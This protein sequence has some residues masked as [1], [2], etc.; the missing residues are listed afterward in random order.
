MARTDD[1]PTDIWT[2]VSVIG[3]TALVVMV[4]GL[5]L[6]NVG[7]ADEKR[8]GKITALEKAD[9]NFI[10]KQDRFITA[11]ETLE[12]SVNSLNTQVQ[13]LSALMPPKKTGD[14]GT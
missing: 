1:K 8:D 13:V 10:K 5:N 6:S 14:S 2:K 4:L 7:R 11:M 12:A 9:E 3:A